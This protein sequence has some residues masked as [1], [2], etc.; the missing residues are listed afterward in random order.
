MSVFLKATESGWYPEFLNPV[1]EVIISN[2]QNKRVLDI[3]T[4]PG[5][6]PEM[7]IKKDK[8]LQVTGIDVNRKMI[9]E[10]T[11]RLKHENI[12]FQYHAHNT[13]L[14]FQD[15]S[16]DVITFCSVLFL[17]E[18]KIKTALMTE[19]LR[20]L[21]PGGEI[22]ILTPLGNKPILTS[23]IEVWQYPFSFYNFTFLIWKLA[24]ASKA[25]SWQ[26]Q[27]WLHQLSI[28][29]KLSYKVSFTFNNNAILEILSK[30]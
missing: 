23:F 27:K 16:F 10:A 17:V 7:L 12:I 18:D 15:N 3:G 6:L 25:K 4:G 28:K 13:P 14:L 19:A 21:K 20:V 1:V 11:H 2:S 5:K 29:N 30:Q 24:T 22:I 9:E 8:E 26:T